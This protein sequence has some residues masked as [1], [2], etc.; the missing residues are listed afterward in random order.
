MFISCG[1]LFHTV[2]RR[3]IPFVTAR[4]RA[5]PPASA[6]ASKEATS[7]A[8][9]PARLGFAGD[10]VEAMWMMLQQAKGETT[11][12]RPAVAPSV[13][14][15]TS[16]SAR[17]SH[18]WKKYV[19]STRA[20]FRPTEVDHLRDDRARRARRGWKPK[21]TFREAREMMVRATRRR[22]P[23][24]GRPGLELIERAGHGRA[25]R[26]R[27]CS[28]RAARSAWRSSGCR[29]PAPAGRNADTPTATSA[30]GALD[31]LGALDSSRDGESGLIEAARG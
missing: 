15:P 30:T 21:I 8:S 28:A 1:I 13:R 9:T 19:R 20:Y 22:S 7:A 31:T 12:W 27:S 18:D 24:A 4:S 14:S 2:P 10:Y 3:I 26:A 17:S 11:W 29:G 16:P 5:R 23:G 25:S 6:T